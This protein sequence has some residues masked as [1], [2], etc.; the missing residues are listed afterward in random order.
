MGEVMTPVMWSDGARVLVR[1]PLP[2]RV[3]K[4]LGATVAALLG[5]PQSRLL[6]SV[7]P[8]RAALCAELGIGDPNGTMLFVV[9]AG[10]RGGA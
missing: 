10:K 6:V 3:F 1:L 7:A 2:P 9:K 4:S 5:V 8:D